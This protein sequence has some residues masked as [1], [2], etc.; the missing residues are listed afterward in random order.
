MSNLPRCA[1]LVLTLGVAAPA[2]ATTGD[3]LG[4]SPSD[5]ALAGAVSARNSGVVATYYNPAA[6][7][8]DGVATFLDEDGP[9]A[10]ADPSQLLLGF[11]YARPSLYAQRLAGGATVPLAAE[12]SDT[13]GLTVGTR[14]DIGAMF[15]Q[16]G[17]N[18]GALIYL[19]TRDIFRWSIH[20][21]DKVQWLFLTD[22]TQ[23]IGIHFGLGW[24]ILPW[25]SVGAGLR[26]L[27]DTETLTS[28][29]V[30]QVE[31]VVDPDTGQS[32][33]DVRTQLG[34][35]VAVY[36]SVAPNVGLLVTPLEDRLRIG[37][38]YRGKLF[39]DDWGW[40]RIQGVPAAGDLGYVHRFA[41]YFEPHTVVASVAARPIEPLWLSVDVSYARW[42]DGLTTNHDTLGS[43]RFG[44]TFTPALG[45]SL[46]LRDE[47]Q[48]RAGYRYQPSPFDNF[49]GPTNLL[50]ADRHVASL[51]AGVDLGTAEDAEVSF[52]LDW[53]LRAAFLIER[54]EHKDPRRFDTDLNYL[55]NPGRAPYRFGGV[56]PGASVSVQASW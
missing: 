2:W 20:A 17:I 5:M 48:L 12:A 29:R 10:E 50:D 37:L 4:F 6:L 56:V 55:R 31:S 39:V 1:I 7:S 43:G 19:P 51:G 52:T 27:F 44:D 32:G 41:H 23:H 49:G 22:R 36:G 21:D 18:L 25:L 3:S 35:D 8:A 24:R 53:A 46:A 34:E 38:T 28:G 15:G 33:F 40:T 26:V 45:A 30:T 16:P 13:H 54:E 42:S 47:V 11:M 9:G 14:F